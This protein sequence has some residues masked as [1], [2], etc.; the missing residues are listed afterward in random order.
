MV[1][2]G[3][4]GAEE[5]GGVDRLAEVIIHAGADTFFA[6]AVHGE[7]GEGD[8]EEIGEG[9]LEEFLGQGKLIGMVPEAWGKEPDQ[10]RA[11][12]ESESRQDHQD[13]SKAPG[14]PIDKELKILA[15]GGFA[16]LAE[17]RNEGLRKGAFSEKPP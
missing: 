12:E 2:Q 5:V 1:E 10:K 16:R 13:E 6:V 9:H 3:V 17:D 15:M 11:Q 7:G 14:D 4:H 8:K